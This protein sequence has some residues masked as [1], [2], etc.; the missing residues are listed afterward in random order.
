[1]AK[2]PFPNLHG[3][4][5]RRWQSNAGIHLDVQL[6]REPAASDLKENVA[7]IAPKLGSAAYQNTSSQ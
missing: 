5:N 3:W 2:T 4:Q 1:L 7:G 6:T